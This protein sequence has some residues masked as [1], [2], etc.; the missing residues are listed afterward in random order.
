[1]ST[2]SITEK[3]AIEIYKEGYIDIDEGQKAGTKKKLCSLGVEFC[4][5]INY[6]LI[7]VKE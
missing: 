3:E 6:N 4:H 2:Y 7:I 1:M 5:D